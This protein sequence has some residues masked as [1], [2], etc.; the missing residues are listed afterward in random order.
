MSEVAEH[1]QVVRREGLKLTLK[2]STDSLEKDESS[3]GSS[4]TV[5]EKKTKH[6]NN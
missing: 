1:W 5:V 2:R 3:E 4:V 6:K